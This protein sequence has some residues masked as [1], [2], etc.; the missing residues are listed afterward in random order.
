ME[1]PPCGADRDGRHHRPVRE[2]GHRRHHAA[3]GTLEPELITS[4]YD[5]EMEDACRC[6][7]TRCEDVVDAIIATETSVSTATKGSLHRHHQRVIKDIGANPLLRRIDDHT[8]ARQ[9]IYLNARRTFT[10]KDRS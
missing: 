2:A 7:S 9:E 1:F 8:A 5:N 10:R 4:I 6:R 3:R